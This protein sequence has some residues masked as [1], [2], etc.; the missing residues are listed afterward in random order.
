MFCASGCGSGLDE[1]AEIGGVYVSRNSGNRV[2]DGIERTLTQIASGQGLTSSGAATK[3]L[4]VFGF[5]Q[6]RPRHTTK[7]VRKQGVS[8]P[9]LRILVSLDRGFLGPKPEI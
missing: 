7:G 9:N 6:G 5:G 1:S 2:Q 4:V 8:E 3:M